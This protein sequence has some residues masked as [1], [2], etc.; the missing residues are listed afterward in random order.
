RVMTGPAKNL[1][2]LRMGQRS[3]GHTR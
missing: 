1:A 2:I 3:V